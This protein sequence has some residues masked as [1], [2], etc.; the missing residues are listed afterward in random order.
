MEIKQ[1]TEKEEVS[2]R[3][4]SDIDEKVAVQKK[5]QSVKTEQRKDRD[6]SEIDQIKTPE[7]NIQQIEKQEEDK[8][9]DD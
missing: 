4:N 6:K 8:S 2:L 1:F 5:F 7:I 9:S 3:K